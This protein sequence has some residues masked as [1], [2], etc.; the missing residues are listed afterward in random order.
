M[1]ALTAYKIPRITGRIMGYREII[2]PE[3]LEEFEKLGESEVRVKF[4]AGL[5]GGR[6]KDH[7]D[8]FLKMCDSEREPDKQI[9]NPVTAWYK[10]WS[11]KIVLGVLI[12]L[13]ILVVSSWLGLG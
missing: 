13:I 4:D 10:N 2:P 3:R 1:T 5:Y 7:A 9:H 8:L 11:E 12:G 6:H